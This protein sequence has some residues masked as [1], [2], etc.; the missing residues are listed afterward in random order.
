MICHFDPNILSLC[1]TL[2]EH[3]ECV[4]S[5]PLFEKMLKNKQNRQMVSDPFMKAFNMCLE[6]EFCRKCFKQCSSG[7]QVPHSR[8]IPGPKYPLTHYYEWTK[9]PHS[10]SGTEIPHS[11]KILGTEIFIH[12]QGPKYPI[13]A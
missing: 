5:D 6:I 10:R 2:H 1:M 9:I 13:H 7:T 4:S 3:F 12:D 11:R 8:K